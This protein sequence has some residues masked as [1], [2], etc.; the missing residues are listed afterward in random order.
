MLAARSC[1]VGQ[2]PASS[3]VLRERMVIPAV[4]IRILFLS[5]KPGAVICLLLPTLRIHGP[6]VRR[7]SA[8]SA[9]RDPYAGEGEE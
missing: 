1:T 4:D 7:R 6:C 3:R 5:V 9:P 8:H 2:I